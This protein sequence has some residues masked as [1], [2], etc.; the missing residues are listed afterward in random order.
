MQRT[1]LSLTTA[2]LLITGCV[3]TPEYSDPLADIARTTGGTKFS[4]VT[5]GIVLNENT[6]KA[7]GYVQKTQKL[8]GS[9][10]ALSNRTAM[11][12][13]DPRYITAGLNRVLSQR[14]RDVVL[15]ERPDQASALGA[16]A[17]MILDIRIKMG[18]ISGMKTTVA[19]SGIFVDLREQPIATVSGE[20]A[21]RVPY[22]AYTLKLKAA[23]TDALAAF[24]KGLDS[25][26][27]LAAALNGGGASVLAAA[28]EGRARNA[29]KPL[30][31]GPSQGFGRYH[32]IVIGNDAY[33]S[34]PR[35]ET[36]VNDARAVARILAERYGFDVTLLTD[37]TR[38]DI[39]RAFNATRRNLDHSDNLLIYYA[40][41]GWLDED[42]ARGYWLPVD[43]LPGDPTNWVS[44]AA[45]TDAVRAVQAKH[46]MIM[47]DSCYSGSLTR[48]ISV[49]LQTPDY[50]SRMASKKARTVMSSGGLEP[51][52]D[53]GGDGHSVFAKALLGALRE[54]SEILDGHTLFSRIRRPVMVNSDQ[55]PEYGD[56]RRA[57]HDGG[58][59]LFVPSAR[60]ASRSN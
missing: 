53:E 31:F 57:G 11:A 27:Q 58:D 15:L 24:A 28:D 32:A 49:S 26:S 30:A 13:G 44:N 34:L 56:I 38:A 41:H 10:G 21:R 46:V 12:D 55:T 16:Q 23:A 47:A 7:I 19:I 29:G 40:G 50:V 22:P 6:R 5:L 1:L 36:A 48:G 18:A 51:V 37:A 14:F 60:P 25:D 9:L 3:Q 8:L 54:N 43:A 45:I 59:F 17:V 4:H 20:G 33:T 42:A 52:L 2:V 35:L 39:L